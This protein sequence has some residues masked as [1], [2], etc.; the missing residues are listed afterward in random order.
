MAF[1][2]DTTVLSVFAPGESVTWGCG[3]CLEHYS[4]TIR[5]LVPDCRRGVHSYMRIQTGA[6]G[7]RPWERAATVWVVPV[8]TPEARCRWRVR[9]NPSARPA[10]Q[11]KALGQA[12][13]SQEEGRQYR[14]GRRPSSKP[15]SPGEPEGAMN[16]AAGSI[17]RPVLGAGGVPP[18]GQKEICAR[19]VTVWPSSLPVKLPTRLSVSHRMPFS[20]SRMKSLRYQFTPAV[21]AQPSP[22]LAAS[23]KSRCS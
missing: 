22:R 16:K 7:P 18:A 19:A 2:R 3:E 11:T 13:P 4:G 15:G 14:I 10:T 9:G 5:E 8:K 1:A 6:C 23:P 12:G 17:R 21:A 20:I